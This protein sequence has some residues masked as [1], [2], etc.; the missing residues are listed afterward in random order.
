MAAEDG[1][2]ALTVRSVRSE[3]SFELKVEQTATVSNLRALISREISYPFHIVARGRLLAD[4]ETLAESGVLTHLPTCR[5]C[6]GTQE[7]GD[8]LGQLFSPCRCSGSMAQVHVECLNLWRRMSSNPTSY[9]QCDQC[10]YRYNVRRT[11]FA[12]MLGSYPVVKV[13]TVVAFLSIVF[14]AGVI[15]RLFAV[16]EFFYRLCLWEPT[17]R[18]WYFEGL[19]HQVFGGC[20]AVGAV[21]F[22]HKIYEETQRRSYGYLGHLGLIVMANG[23][24]IIRVLLFC[25]V[26]YSMT[27]AYREVKDLWSRM[28]L[29]WGEVVLDA[30]RHD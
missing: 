1:S 5:I 17:W 9:F 12:S 23:Q 26:A 25:G 8:G 18:G 6:H 13:S 24:M 7:D 11:Q 14:V 3:D 20:L 29:K 30:Q 2:V 16:E 28:L 21:G 10:G 15:T 4:E 27:V 19:L 22:L